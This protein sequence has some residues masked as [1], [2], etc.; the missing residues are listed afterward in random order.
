MYVCMCVYDCMYVCLSVCMYV[1]MSV[2]VCVR[3]SVLLLLY[4]SISIFFSL[5]LFNIKWIRY[6][7]IAL[8]ASSPMSASS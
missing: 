4:V 3:V 2:C 6:D 5:Q 7:K 8:L 1:C